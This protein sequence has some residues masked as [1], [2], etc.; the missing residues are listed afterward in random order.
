MSSGR[1]GCNFRAGHALPLLHSP[2]R[3]ETKTATIARDAPRAA[4]GRLG[5]AFAAL[6]LALL[7]AIAAAWAAGRLRER[8]EVD[9]ADA[10]LAS[11][12]RAAT[13]EVRRE[14]GDA[15]ARARVL[16]ASPAVQRAFV[17]Q[18]RAALA[19]LAEAGGTVAFELPGGTTVGAAESP[20]RRAVEVRNERGRLLGRVLV[21]IPLDMQLIG[22]L[23]ATSGVPAQDTL[24]VT[25]G[26]RYVTAAPPDGDRRSMAVPLAGGTDLR[27]VAFT[28]T[29]PIDDAT[30]DTR[31]RVFLATLLTVLLL[32]LG[33]WA[34][35]RMLA[36]G[37]AAVAAQRRRADEA[38]AAASTGRRVR[39][40]VAL[41]GEALAATHDP[42]A[43]LPVI[44]ESA[45]GATG[46]VGARLVSEGAERFRAGRPERGGP[47]L[48]L[49]LDTEGAHVGSLLLYPPPGRPFSED[50]GRLAHWLAAQASIALENARLHRTVEQ[51]A[52]TDHLTGLA[53]RRR[54]SET[55]SL[56]VSRAERFE[57]SLALVLADLDDFKRVNDRYGHH[58]GDEVLRRFAAVMMENVREF[59]LAVR[60]GG[61]EF[62]VLLPETDIDGGVRLAERLAEALRRSRFATPWGEFSVTASFGVAAFPAADSAEQLVF[63][64]DRALY[65]AK[66]EGKDRVAHAGSEGRPIDVL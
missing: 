60:H 50:E 9:T 2:G 64:A 3:G 22:R 62:A 33:G 52:I 31:R 6:A 29:E 65:Q 24:A 58:I 38:G 46:A 51:Q 30:F 43:L 47:P 37:P 28:P 13:A 19:R 8:S 48:S 55:L 26:G 18:N 59:D 20:L 25:D 36:T 57:G 44:L 7:L 32:A 61:E 45:V 12:L 16:S 66:S 39:E 23:R 17:R 21:S 11:S 14:L 4:R 56:E 53:N 63:A 54:F 34:L 5:L 15:A 35:A 41:V 40:A 49:S 10:R 1:R 27:L 42:D